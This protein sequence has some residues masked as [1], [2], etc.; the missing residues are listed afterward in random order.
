MPLHHSG[1]AY[2][3]LLTHGIMCVGGRPASRATSDTHLEGRPVRRRGE[4]RGRDEPGKGAQ[5]S[6]GAWS[7]EEGGTCQ[8]NLSNEAPPLL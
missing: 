4:H 2:F 6:V 1:S 7:Q 3:C 5:P 8:G